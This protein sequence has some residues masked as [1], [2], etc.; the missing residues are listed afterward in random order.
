[1]AGSDEQ[2]F[3]RVHGAIEVLGDLG[4]GQAVEVAQGECGAVVRAQLGENLVG[5]HPFE[6]LV[7]AVVDATSGARVRLRSSARHVDERCF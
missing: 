5:A 6:V 3:G 7:E 1:M 2:R 4:D